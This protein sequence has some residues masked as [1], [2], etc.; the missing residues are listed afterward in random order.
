MNSHTPHDT[1]H[2]SQQVA[3]NPILGALSAIECVRSAYAEVRYSCSLI[4]ELFIHFLRAVLCVSFD[5]LQQ[6]TCIAL[7]HV[8]HARFERDAAKTASLKARRSSIS[9]SS[10]SSVSA[11]DVQATVHVAAVLQ[12]FLLSRAHVFIQPCPAATDAHAQYHGAR[13][14]AA[15]LP[16]DV[17]V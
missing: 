4:E 5:S 1:R 7:L 14:R 13:H 16:G 12:V 11:F 17:V 3:S 9:T 2:T 8:A 10:S 6:V 15:L